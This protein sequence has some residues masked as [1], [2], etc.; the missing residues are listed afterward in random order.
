MNFLSHFYFDRHSANPELVLGC[1]MPDLV[2]TA[3]ILW[4]IHPEKKPHLFHES[5]KM[6]SLL[7]G[8]KKHLE[9][10]RYFHNCDFFTRHTKAIREM[11][12][13]ILKNSQIRPSFLAHISLELMLDS[14]LLNLEEIDAFEFYEKL[15]KVERTVLKDFLELN[16]IT[17]TP[18]FFRFFDQFL[19]ENYLHSYIDTENL[20][21]SLS[22]VCLRLWPQALTVEEKF[23]LQV[24]LLDYQEHLETCYKDIFED[25]DRHLKPAYI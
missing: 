23:K 16:L 19:A 9:I 5:E 8:W 11:V 18:R 24:V 21:Y 14:L 10:D 15:A 25:L 7:E 13:P 22:N 2:K 3:N 20:I 1:V 4:I 12:A 6:Q 17:D